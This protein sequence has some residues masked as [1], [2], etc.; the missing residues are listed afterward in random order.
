MRPRLQIV[1]FNLNR[2]L[3]A[4][5]TDGKPIFFLPTTAF[6]PRN[7]GVTERIVAIGT[8]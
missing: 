7:P 5:V 6:S 4:I 1:P 8:S 3:Y 2:L